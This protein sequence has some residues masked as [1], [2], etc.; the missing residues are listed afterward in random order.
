MSEV[1]SDMM[2]VL[3]AGIGVVLA[4]TTLF[5]A[6]T[7]VMKGNS[8]TIAMLRVF[9]YSDRECAGAILSG[10]RPITYVGFALGSAYQHGLMTMMLSMFFDSELLE[11]PDY[12]FN[13]QACIFSFI[14]FVVLYEIFMRVYSEKMKRIPLKEVML[15]E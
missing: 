13:W 8:K 12:S 15:E 6:V 2:A 3:M 5:I 9:G 7:T 4:V 1:S 10:Y 14:S 11:I